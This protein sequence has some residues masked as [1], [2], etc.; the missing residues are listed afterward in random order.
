MSSPAKPTLTIDLKLEGTPPP[1]PQRPT[2]ASS[3]REFS[4]PKSAPPVA[5]NRVK[6]KQADGRILIVPLDS[7]RGGA[8]V[9]SASSSNESSASQ[10]PKTK[11]DGSNS[12]P[13]PHRY[14]T[15]GSSTVQVPD[16]IKEVEDD[17]K[18]LE[19]GSL[20]VLAVDND[21]ELDALFEESK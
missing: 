1:T 13:L 17:F 16:D 19:V 21:E 18:D 11:Q 8:I 3:P 20:I 5:D 6:L 12:A 7:P 10:S 14:E 4:Q 2:A 15:N 9:V